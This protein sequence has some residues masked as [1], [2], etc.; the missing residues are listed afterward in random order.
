M[1]IG[2]IQTRGLGDI[3]I[4]APIAQYYIDRG[5]EVYWPIDS[6]FIDSCQHA[7]PSIKFIPINKEKTGNN[8]ADYFFN[9]PNESLKLL[10]CEIIICLYS[11]LTGFDFNQGRLPDSISFDA[12][13]YAV[14]KVP[15]REKW[16][17][18]LR[19]NFQSEGKLFEMLNLKPN[20]RYA[21]IHDEGSVHKANM[22]EI[23]PS[24]LRPIKVK[25]ITKNFLDW[26]GV[27]E[28]AES[29]YLVNSVYSNLADQLNF[30]NKK[31]LYM[32][33]NAQWTPV[34]INDWNY[35]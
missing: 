5:F 15:F 31:F 21:V 13:K 17:L 24:D 18:K 16:R 28:N 19:R 4:A 25:E 29:L 33:T 2:I 34:L 27:L 14:A 11:H 7:F 12:Y 22:D 3:I 10:N 1:K 20:E 26:I 8:T 23:I 6:A 35:I 30:N 32:H 9:E